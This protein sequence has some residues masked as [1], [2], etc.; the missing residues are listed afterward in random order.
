V[1]PNTLHLKWEVERGQK[2]KERIGIEPRRGGKYAGIIAINAKRDDNYAGRIGRN[3]IR[4]NQD[5][6]LSSAD[7]EL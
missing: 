2:R 5:V 6:L 4:Q 7:N 1:R 3:V